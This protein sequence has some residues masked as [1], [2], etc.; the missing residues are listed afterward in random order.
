MSLTKPPVYLYADNHKQKKR[1]TLTWS[2]A[3]EVCEEGERERHCRT[4]SLT[5]SQGISA[6]QGRK[7]D[8]IS[9]VLHCLAS[10]PLE[11]IALGAKLKQ[12]H[13]YRHSYRQDQGFSL[14]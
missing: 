8:A 2:N 9:S 3:A 12:S 7:E 4:C 10:H 1:A 5:R 6:G 13:R 11:G 14:A